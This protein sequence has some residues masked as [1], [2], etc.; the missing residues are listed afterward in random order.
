MI[1][2]RAC[3][4]LFYATIIFIFLIY[5]KNIEMLVFLDEVVLS[6]AA[7]NKCASKSNIYID[8]KT[9]YINESSKT[10]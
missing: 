2:V 6:L 10:D 7:W 3:V 4:N 1:S 9:Q 5:S 8:K